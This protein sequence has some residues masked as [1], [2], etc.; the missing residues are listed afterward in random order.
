MQRIPEQTMLSL[1]IQ[2][3]RMLLGLGLVFT[4]AYTMFSGREPSA[5]VLTAD[6]QWRLKNIEPIDWTQQD[7][8]R[9]AGSV[10]VPDAVRGLHRHS[11]DGQLL[12]ALT[13][14]D[15]RRDVLPHQGALRVK[16]LLLALARLKGNSNL[17]PSANAQLLLQEGALRARCSA[18]RRP[19]APPLSRRAD[20]LRAL[21]AAGALAAQLAG[22]ASAAGA[23]WVGGDG[24]SVQVY[25]IW[26]PMSQ[27][28][29]IEVCARTSVLAIVSGP[30][31]S[32]AATARAHYC[33][34]GPRRCG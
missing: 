16:K 1:D 5:V 12:L 22:N 3:V 21:T 26:E 6:Q 33:R 17:P 25:R 18:R 24:E 4:F 30:R 28:A 19:R 32:P 10:G 13:E 20:P 7:V 29:A 9:W 27:P 15:V 2:T 8:E 31:A 14:E 11:V 34:R 23:G